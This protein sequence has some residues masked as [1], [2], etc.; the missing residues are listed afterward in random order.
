MQR[1]VK[2]TR[3]TR[4]IRHATEDERLTLEGLCAA[5]RL[6]HGTSQECGWYK[7]AMTGRRLKHN[8]GERIAL[9]HSELSEALEAHRRDAMDDKLSGRKGAEVELADA[10][11]RIFDLAGSLDLDLSGAFVE[12]NRF[13][14]QR[15]DHKLKN[16]AKRGGKKY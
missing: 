16:R 5:I 2:H 9:I 10:L 7:C 3:R 14:A 11:L 13:N 4:V 12:K 1:S 6:A 8:F 15:A